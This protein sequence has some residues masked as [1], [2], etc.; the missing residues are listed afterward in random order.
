MTHHRITAANVT[1]PTGSG[2]QTTWDIGQATD[3]VPLEAGLLKLGITGNIVRWRTNAAALKMAL[4]ELIPYKIPGDI[5]RLIHQH[6]LLPQTCKPP[7]YRLVRAFQDKSKNG[8]AVLLERRHTKGSHLDLDQICAARIHKTACTTWAEDGTDLD[9]FNIIDRDELQRLYDFYKTH[10]G[11]Q[12]VGEM[13]TRILESLPLAQR[14]GKRKGRWH[15]PDESADLWCE[16]ADLV[17][18]CNRDTRNQTVVEIQ[19]MVFTESTLRACRKS[20]MEEV[21][22][23]CEDIAKE[24]AEGTLGERG[25]INRQVEVTKCRIKVAEYGAI[26]GAFGDD[27]K[28]V[29]SGVDN[30]I[31]AARA[32]DDL[33]LDDLNLL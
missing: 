2:I 30:A 19:P 26:V 31:S 24:L 5:C 23:R 9:P 33:M 27:L 17:E 25:L 21:K 6:G 13:L 11:G 8:Y 1:V 20:M 14:L 22:Q 7:F 32:M 12:E 3:P 16:V 18:S 4:G 28:S 29:L 10:L 15:I